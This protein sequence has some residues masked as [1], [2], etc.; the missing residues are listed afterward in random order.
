MLAVNEAIRD[1]ILGGA[2]T[3][4]LRRLAA[5]SGMASISEDAHRKVAEGVTSPHEIA[6]VI[7][8]DVG[9]VM[10]C[11]ACGSE[12]PWEAIGCPYCGKVTR[13]LCPCGAV[14]RAGWKFCAASLRLSD[15]RIVA[16]IITV[17]LSGHVMT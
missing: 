15:A 4:T 12:I 9:A 1:E 2:S 17:L 10:P 5:E 6:R 7:Q 16:S 11:E 14:L 3:S 8:S 13:R